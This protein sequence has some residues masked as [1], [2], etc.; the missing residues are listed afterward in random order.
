MSTD[1]RILEHM[2]LQ[3]QEFKKIYDYIENV[4][5]VEQ[6]IAHY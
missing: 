1:H 5:Q 6:G 2:S 4:K 3:K